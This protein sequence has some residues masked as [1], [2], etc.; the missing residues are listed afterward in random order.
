MKARD[1]LKRLDEHQGL[2]LAQI[3]AGVLLVE[4]G[5]GAM[6]DL[7]QARW[8]FMRMLREYQA[9]K[10]AE[11]FDPV[12]RSGSPRQVAVAKELRAACI[13]AMDAYRTY[14]M[15][16][17]TVDTYANWQDYRLAMLEMAAAIRTH[18]ERER[19]EIRSLLATLQRTRAAAAG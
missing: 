10:H 14:T 19:V 18:V 15:R 9:F 2:V 11:I 4:R 12:I 3:S 6:P 7:A 8:K 16:W 13:A 17:S 5:P 1:A